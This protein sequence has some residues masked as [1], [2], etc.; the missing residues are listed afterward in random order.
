MN[1]CSIVAALFMFLAVTIWG[2]KSYLDTGESLSWCYGLSFLV[3][4]AQAACGVLFLFE[5]RRP[6]ELGD[7]QLHLLSRAL[8]AQ[9]QAGEKFVT[10]APEQGNNPIDLL[11]ID[12]PH[13][14]TTMR[15]AFSGSHYGSKQLLDKA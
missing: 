1:H 13:H 15:S 11:V 7:D 3:I 12:A 14:D 10:H 4:L 9:E 5:L 2:G 6:I 8:D